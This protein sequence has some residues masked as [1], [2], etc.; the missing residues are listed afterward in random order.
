[1][2]IGFII[3]G[4][5]KK[6]PEHILNRNLADFKSEL[7]KEVEKFKVFESN[8][9]IRK[10]EKFS[11]FTEV[12]NMARNSVKEGKSEKEVAR[13]LENA[14]NLF[15]KDLIFFAGEG[16]LKKFVEYRNY[17]DI[18]RSGGENEAA[19]FQFLIAELILEMR[20]DLGYTNDGL[21][22]DHYMYLTINDWDIH[23]N[24]YSERAK[25]ALKLKD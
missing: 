17:S 18:V 3:I 9:H 14:M 23:K 5:I 10:I 11:Q 24:L 15:A 25:K 16:T 7:Q 22:V 1:M 12:L 13:K 6:T 4:I 21:T 20:R 2:I 19:K 8:L